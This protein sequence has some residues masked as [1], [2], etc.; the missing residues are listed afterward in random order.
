[1]R[2][3]LVI[4][5]GLLAAW[6]GAA[7]PIGALASPTTTA[8]HGHDSHHR[9]VTISLATT[10]R[11][12]PAADDRYAIEAAV[13]HRSHGASA[14]PDRATPPVLFAYDHPALLVRVDRTSGT[15]QGQGQ[16]L[17]ADLAS[18]SGTRIAA[19][20]ADEA[21]AGVDDVLG[22]LSKG[23]QSTV[24][25][26]GSDAELQDVYATLSRG[27]NPV[28]VSGYKGLW[29][30]RPDGVRIGLRDVSKSGGRT[31]DIRYPDGT[32]RKVHI[33]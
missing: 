31:I 1:M 16:V 32:I 26:V 29:I 13:D 5:I 24:R 2:R 6:L 15:T 12:P 4:I 19:K 30:E 20:G 23:Q 7:A 21:L 25:T 3:L 28:E 10:E 22:G 9:V 18:I 27:G 17:S 8:A 11:G 33:E 14:R